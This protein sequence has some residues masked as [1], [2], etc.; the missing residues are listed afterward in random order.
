MK[1]IFL[2]IDGVLN[3][4][5]S[6]SKMIDDNDVCYVGID[7]HKILRL[8][9]T[10]DRTGAKVVLSSTWRLHLYKKD[11]VDKYMRQRFKKYG[12]EIY[13]CTDHL[14]GSRGAEIKKWLNEHDNIEEWVVLDDEWF[15]DYDDEILQHLV[16]TSYYVNPGGLR[17]ENI[18]TV[19]DILNGKLQKQEMPIAS[20]PEEFVHVGLSDYID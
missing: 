5:G 3:C 11:R 8:K 15:S 9:E 16:R 19:C 17:D 18:D 10:I 12:I 2:D 7:K 1:I 14:H 13:S 20:K 4:N 6:K